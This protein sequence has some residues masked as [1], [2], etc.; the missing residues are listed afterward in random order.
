LAKAIR[1]EL[2]LANSGEFDDRLRGILS[3]KQLSPLRTQLKSDLSIYGQTYAESLEPH[4]VFFLEHS[5]VDLRS[6]AWKKAVREARLDDR[7][8]QKSER[9]DDPTQSIVLPVQT[10]VPFSALELLDPKSKPGD[11]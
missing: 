10:A 5:R 6:R 2:S 3:I 9:W 4:E 11:S 8:Q 7:S 1:E